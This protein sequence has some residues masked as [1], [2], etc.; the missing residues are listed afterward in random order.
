M[1]D[2]NGHDEPINTAVK[3]LVL[4]HRASPARP[5]GQMMIIKAYPSV[6]L[7]GK[8]WALEQAL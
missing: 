6:L 4:T 2:D 8:N 1:S 5:M 3:N 7:R